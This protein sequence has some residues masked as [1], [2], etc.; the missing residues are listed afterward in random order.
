LD[1]TGIAYSRG[2]DKDLAKKELKQALQLNP[3][4]SGAEEA[5]K[6]L[7]GLN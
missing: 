1:S 3:K 5:K 2:R 7:Q 6:A 4:F